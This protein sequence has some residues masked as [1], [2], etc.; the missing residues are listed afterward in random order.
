MKT[1]TLP[2]QKEFDP[3]GRSIL[4]I[5]TRVTPKAKSYSGDPDRLGRIATVLAIEVRAIDQ[6]HVA[7]DEFGCTHEELYRVRYDDGAESVLW[8]DEVIQCAEETV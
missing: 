7:F 2:Q 6:G 3:K 5:G 8:A 4:T 1:W